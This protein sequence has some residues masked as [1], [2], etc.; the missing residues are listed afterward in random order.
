MADVEDIISGEM[1]VIKQRR[2]SIN[3]DEMRMQAMFKYA[4][5]VEAA[6]VHNPSKPHI[7]VTECK[8]GHLFYTTFLH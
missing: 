7:L 5:E 3:G 4:K 2:W 6:R 1:S 8:P